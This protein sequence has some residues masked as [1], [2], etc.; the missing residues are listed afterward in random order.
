MTTTSVGNTLRVDAGFSP[1]LNFRVFQHGVMGGSSSAKAD[2]IGQDVEEETE[3]WTILLA[4]IFQWTRRM[5]VFSTAKGVVVRESKTESSAQ[6]VANELS[7]RRVVVG[8]C[9]RQDAWR[10]SFFTG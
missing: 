3:Q 4:S 6:A 1:P 10:R 2:T 9:S 5:F 8:S 7:K